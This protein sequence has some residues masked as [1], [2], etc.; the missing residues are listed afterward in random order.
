MSLQSI[1]KYGEAMDWK[2]DMETLNSE[3]ETL[4][5]KVTACLGSVQEGC[6]GDAVNSLVSTSGQMQEKF[7]GLIRAAGQLVSALA[8]VIRKYEEF[9]DSVLQK[10][11]DTAGNILGGITI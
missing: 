5:G 8:E 2:Q 1:F 3:T 10:I 7:T 4:L 9:E 6:E 11:K